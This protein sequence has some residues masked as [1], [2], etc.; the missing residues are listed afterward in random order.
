M[1][2]KFMEEKEDR[3]GEEIL[4]DATTLMPINEANFDS[5]YP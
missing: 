5:N 2:M 4:N 3:F 1:M